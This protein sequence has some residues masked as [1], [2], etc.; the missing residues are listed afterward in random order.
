[1]HCNKSTEC[2]QMLVYGWNPGHLITV[3]CFVNTIQLQWSPSQAQPIM[4][5]GSGSILAPPVYEHR[6]KDGDGERPKTKFIFIMKGL[7]NVTNICMIRNW[8][9]ISEIFCTKI[10]SFFYFTFRKFLE[11]PSS[12]KATLMSKLLIYKTV[13]L[14]SPGCLQIGRLLLEPSRC[15]FYIWINTFHSRALQPT[16]MHANQPG[17]QISTKLVTNPL[18]FKMNELKKFTKKRFSWWAWSSDFS[19]RASYCVVLWCLPFLFWLT[20]IVWVYGCV[21]LC[22]LICVCVWWQLPGDFHFAF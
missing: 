12:L 2:K 11:L 17:G 5:T 7:Q 18:I 3:L 21:C 22:R 15:Q 4:A 6:L 16:R 1:M 14:P 20:K 19:D 10:N 9:Q 13:A 8:A